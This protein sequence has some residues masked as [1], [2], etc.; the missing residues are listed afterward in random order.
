[1]LHISLNNYLEFKN[2]DEYP[3]MRMVKVRNKMMLRDRI[4]FMD[5]FCIYNIKIFLNILILLLSWD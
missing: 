2:L 5:T 4:I 1:M 3:E